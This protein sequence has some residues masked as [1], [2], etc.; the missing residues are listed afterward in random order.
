MLRVREDNIVTSTMQQR[1]GR[2]LDLAN[3]LGTS[4]KLWMNL[5][6]TWDLDRAIKRRQVA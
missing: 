3:A 4:A 5:Q 6:A 1:N 2:Y